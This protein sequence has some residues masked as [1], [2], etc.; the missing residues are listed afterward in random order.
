MKRRRIL[1]GLLGIPIGAGVGISCVS[2]PRQKPGEE[3][4]T[5]Q[6]SKAR[7]DEKDADLLKNAKQNI[8]SFRKGN[9]KINLR[10]GGKPIS[11]SEFELV[12]IKHDFGF[13][14]TQMGEKTKNRL[15][16]SQLK[17]LGNIFNNFTAKCYWNE[18]WHQPIE[19]IEGQR[20][21]SVFESEIAIAKSLGMEVKGHPLVWTV[22]KALPDWF[23]KYPYEVRLEKMLHHV[24]DLV[25][26]YKGKVEL[27]DLCN[28]FL[29]EPS[30]RHTEDRK[31]PHIESL[32]E[33]LTYLEP[34]MKVARKANPNA[35]FVLNDYGLEKDYRTEISAKTQRTRY[36]ELVTEMKKRGIAPDA[37]GTQCHVAEPFTMNEI[38]TCLDQ[39]AEPGLPLQITE[40]WSRIDKKKTEV[41]EATL[42]YIENAYTIGFGHKSMELF[43]YW[44]G[45]LILDNGEPSLK[46]QAIEKLITK[47]WNTKTK[48]A[49]DEKGQFE[50]RGFYGSYSLK[51]GGKEI[52]QFHFGK[53]DNQKEIALDLN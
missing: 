51:M 29:W 1:K 41:D 47:E 17:R 5:N 8:E 48:F 44:G 43:T 20:I 50:T 9:L 36:V 21:Y 34:A 35:R 10:N 13:G 52:K 11:N 28:E 25:G 30:L 49:T 33:I 23:K 37:I 12:Q 45:D 7:E 15:N 19:T 32:E 4:R 26:R 53:I 14:F 24:E 46:L 16:E 2:Y 42:A 27:W 18:R 40:F 31:W 6:I 3:W 22:P 38:Q 39:L